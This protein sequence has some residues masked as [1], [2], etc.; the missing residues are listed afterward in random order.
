MPTPFDEK[1][2]LQTPK[3][4]GIKSFALQLDACKLKLVWIK[5]KKKIYSDNFV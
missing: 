2:T 4:Y 1:K 5:M 3:L